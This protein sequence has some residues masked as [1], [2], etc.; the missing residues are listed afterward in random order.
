LRQGLEPPQSPAAAEKDHELE[1]GQDGDRDDRRSDCTAA[2][3]ARA[4]EGGGSRLDE[5]TIAGDP[6][7][8][9]LSMHDAEAEISVILERWIRVRTIALEWS[10][11]P[12]ARNR[13]PIS[14]T[15]KFEQ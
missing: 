8:P 2:L 1:R 12:D 14:S 9:P 15:V 7:D 10:V 13:A 3:D 4:D 5:S 11:L 6:L